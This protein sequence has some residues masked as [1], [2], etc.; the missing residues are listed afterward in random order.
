MDATPRDHW[1]TF[2]L[3]A[4]QTLIHGAVR[5]R[6]RKGRDLDIKMLVTLINQL[7]GM[8]NTIEQKALRS[9]PLIMFSS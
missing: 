8:A 3:M 2:L 9:L 7:V 4:R 5:F 6:Q 1:L